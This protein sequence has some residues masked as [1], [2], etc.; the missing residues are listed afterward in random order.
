[1]T[2][3]WGNIPNGGVAFGVVPGGSLVHLAAYREDGT[4]VELRAVCGTGVTGV[5]FASGRLCH[6]CQR[7]MCID[8]MSWFG[9]DEDASAR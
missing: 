6:R 1:M 5:A 4:G 2:L 3:R 7:I 9:Y 8:D